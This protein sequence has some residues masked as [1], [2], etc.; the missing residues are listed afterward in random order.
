MIYPVAWFLGWSVLYL[1]SI[2]LRF[3]GKHSLLYASVQ[4]LIAFTPFALP[5]PFK[6]FSNVF[7]SALKNYHDCFDGLLLNVCIWNA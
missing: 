5:S 6:C 3:D 2:V 4:V 7:S 1:S